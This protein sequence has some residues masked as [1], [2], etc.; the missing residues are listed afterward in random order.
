MQQ[1]EKFERDLQPIAH[2]LRKDN[3]TQM[4]L[5]REARAEGKPWGLEKFK[6]VCGGWLRDKEIEEW[7]EG[8]GLGAELKEAQVQVEKHK[9]RKA[10]NE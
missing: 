1:I 6:A 3:K 2:K 7:L 5:W 4:G 9:E 10:V 8:K